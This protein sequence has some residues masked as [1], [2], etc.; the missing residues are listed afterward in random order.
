MPSMEIE[1]REDRFGLVRLI[2]AN[3][4]IDAGDLR[5]MG[6]LEVGAAEASG[7][8]VDEVGKLEY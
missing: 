7:V 8:L 6:V 3:Q 2:R 1:Q 4:L 5:L